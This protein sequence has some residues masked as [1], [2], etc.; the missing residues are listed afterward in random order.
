[1]ATYQQLLARRACRPDQL[2]FVT[3]EMRDPKAGEI[4]LRIQATG[5]S[6]GDLMRCAGRIPGS[7][8]PYVP[9]YDGVGIIDAV[10]DDVHTLSVGQIA[11]ALPMSNCH[12]EYVIMPASHALPLP[13]PDLSITDV[14]ALTMNYLTAYQ[15]LHHVAHVQPG[16]RILVHG[17]A[18]GVG[19]ALLQLA[20][21]HGVTTFGTASKKKH[22]I[23]EQLGGIPIDYQAED[24]VIRVKSLTDGRGV[25]AAFDPIGG[26]NLW[27]SNQTLHRGGSLVCYGVSSALHTPL[28]LPLTLAGLGAAKLMG[29]SASFY[30]VSPK[31]TFQVDLSHLLDLLRQHKIKPIIAETLPFTDA[32]QGYSL[33][34]RGVVTGKVVMEMGG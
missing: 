3:S 24:F 27:R 20:A 6:F 11:A 34:E 13:D 2:E 21:L 17:A 16:N 14:A 8:F 15:M 31:G 26:R 30:A 7:K 33:L 5:I 25:D 4:R 32:R 29:R 18:G 19:S 12:A 1:M 28:N 22:T 9:G 23:V 10:G